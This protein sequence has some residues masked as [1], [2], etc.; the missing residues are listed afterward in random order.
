M[1]K[2][3][4]Q[5]ILNQPNRLEAGGEG[6]VQPYSGYYKQHKSDSPH[7]SKCKPRYWTI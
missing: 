1:K 2:M 4:V 5:L 7:E 3:N 6:V